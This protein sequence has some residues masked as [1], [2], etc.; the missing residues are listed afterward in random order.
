MTA[1][2]KVTLTAAVALLSVAGGSGISTAA[3]SQPADRSATRCSAG[4]RTL[5]HYGEHV[6]PETGNGGYRSIHTDVHLSYDAASNTFLSGTHVDLTERATQ[7]L[8]EFSLDFQRTSAAGLDGP[9]L[10]VGS[11]TV[12]GRPA[13]FRFVQPT[14]PGDPNGQNDPDPRAH[15]ASQQNPVGGARHNPLPPACTPELTADTADAQDGQQC[16]ANKLV[17]IPRKPLRAG[18]SFVVSVSYTGRPGVHVDGD[19]STEGWFR[20]DS[21]AGDGGF[22]TTEPVGTEAWMPLNDHPSAKPTYDFYDT[23][24][25]GK[26]AV[27]NG[28][29]V[30]TR[31][32]GPSTPFPGGS[33]T[34]HWRSGAPV[35]SYLVENSVG[36]FDLSER[37]A[38]NGIRF[39]EAQPSSLS[40][41]QK[42]ANLAIM[43]Q[44]QDITRFQSRFN[45]PFPF[46]SD[47]VLIGLP[48]ASFEEEMQTMITFAG[49]TID[50]DTFNHENMHQ[51]W[52]DN[53]SEANYNLTF[54][55]EG[56]ATLGEYLFAARTAETAAGG[57]HT[58]AG[59]AAFQ[60]SLVDQFN[61]SYA[62]SDL[63]SGVP[64]DPTPYTLFSGTTT[65]TRP[66]TAYL[67]L[68][69]ILGSDNFD[70]ALQQLQR[71]YGGA[72]ITEAQ[73]EAGFARWLPDRSASCQ[74][75]LGTF[76]SQ[77]FDTAY[78]SGA[79]KP[80]ITGP[81]LDGGGF[82]NSHGGCG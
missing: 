61:S 58:V 32:N 79:G 69:Q 63:W 23:V 1:L 64:S 11:V 37:T 31:H 46:R 15:Q 56:L 16:P 68:R 77:W 75:E 3:A 44:Q 60:K 53:V 36:S 6:Y 8:T 55:K 52:G 12:N 39:Y 54:Y 73:L 13:A 65:Y 66:G 50:L 24:N 18:D 62:R 43:N 41:A 10:S 57:E 51:W 20:S 17:I 26:T 19:G 76:F 49:G 5:S 67:A 40:P 71:R 27:A 2:R 9:D 82:Y 38:A 81:G 21:P 45:G 4:A 25:A 42:A 28:I 33:T 34:W 74:A 7:C 48:S 59:R 35:A 72:T 78:P 70:R 22:V 47:G 14:Y 80:T 29:L 30:S